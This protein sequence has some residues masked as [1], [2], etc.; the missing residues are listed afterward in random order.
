MPANSSTGTTGAQAG[1]S[2]M[3]RAE[4]VSMFERRQAAYDNLD[5]A[6]LASDYSDDCV[7]ESPTGG[8]HSGRA[9]VQQTFEASRE[10]ASADSSAC[11]RAAS[12]SVW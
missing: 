10:P 9:A 5:A 6:A 1:E 4:I 7:V 8:T 12:P 3:T 11:R 2:R